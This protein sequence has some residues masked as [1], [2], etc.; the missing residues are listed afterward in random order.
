MREKINEEVSVVMYYSARQRAARPHLISWQNREYLVDKIG[1]HHSVF[2]GRDR[3][4]ISELTV[5]G[6]SLWMR[7]N[8]NTESL[9]WTLEIVSDGL[10]S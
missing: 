7:L 6:V 5:K 10:A 9:H 8:L 4:H 2:D 1:Y 3:H